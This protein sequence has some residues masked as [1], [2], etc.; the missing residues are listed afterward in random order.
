MSKEIFNAVYERWSAQGKLGLTE[1]YNTEAAAEAVLP[2]GVMSIP[3]DV[4][5]WTL[6]L[7]ETFENCQLQFNLYSGTPTC[8]EIETCWAALVAAFDFH[9]LVV[10]GS[11]TV[12]LTRGVTIRR[13][14]ESIWSYTTMY[15]LS[16]GVL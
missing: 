9:D 11:V 4:P 13:R 3:S 8:E 1:L 10:T 2:Y 5:D 12:S 6:A 16:T 15:N 7:D 14:V